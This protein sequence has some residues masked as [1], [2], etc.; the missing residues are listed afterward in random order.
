MPS[1]INT[2]E[3]FDSVIAPL[4]T[5]AVKKYG[6]I[7]LSITVNNDN[8]EIIP[9]SILCNSVRNRRVEQLDSGSVLKVFN[10]IKEAAESTNSLA[11]QI[12]NCCNGKIKT[13]RGYQWRYA[14]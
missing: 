9:T 1:V 8:I 11:N 10:S 7:K 13:H 4:W 12:S 3:K 14:S 5:S 2:T 6:D